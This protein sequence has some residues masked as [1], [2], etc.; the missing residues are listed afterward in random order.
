MDHLFG[1]LRELYDIPTDF[2]PTLK[3]VGIT[4]HHNRKKRYIDMSILGYVKKA[5]QRFQRIG[6]KLQQTSSKTPLDEPY[7]L[8]TS[9]KTKELQEIVGVF[10]FYAR[11]DDQSIYIYI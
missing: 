11:A 3:Y 2:S 6:S 9:A 7:S 5:M 4:L 10:L 8:L 1:V